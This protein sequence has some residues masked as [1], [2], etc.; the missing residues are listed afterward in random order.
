MLAMAQ[1]DDWIEIRFLKYDDD[2]VKGN[3]FVF[4]CRFLTNSIV[5]PFFSSS[6]GAFRF[7]FELVLT[8]LSRI[9]SS[10]SADISRNT[11]SLQLTKP[12]RKSFQAL[13]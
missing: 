4:G 1:Y 6:S 13:E 9:V 11:C 2:D 3:I 5:R 7:A 8:C 12:R 10:C